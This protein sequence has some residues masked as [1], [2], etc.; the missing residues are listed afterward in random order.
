MSYRR[1]KDDIFETIKL[2]IFLTF[3]TVMM[4][5]ILFSP[6][7][8][9]SNTSTNIPAETPQN[10]VGSYIAVDTPAGSTTPKQFTRATS[11]GNITTFL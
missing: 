6:D 7:K 2:Y 11:T 1:A 9:I 10:T 8:T 3:A 4:I 5:L